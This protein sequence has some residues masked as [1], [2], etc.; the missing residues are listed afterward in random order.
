MM[1]TPVRR[2]MIGCVNVVVATTILVLYMIT[3]A[4]AF[5]ATTTKGS[6]SFDRTSQRHYYRSPARRN[7]S[8]RYMSNHFMDRLPNESDDSY[9]RR[10]VTTASNPQSFENA[11]LK[12]QPL[13]ANVSDTAGTGTE[14][15]NSTSSGSKYVRAEVWEEQEREKAKSSSNWEERVQFDGQIHGNRFNQNEILRHNL[16]GF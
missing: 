1:M 5:T 3:T 16:K 4:T 15:T 11:V 12:S 6:L 2:W 7:H 10:I 8:P 14:T 13:A 9:F